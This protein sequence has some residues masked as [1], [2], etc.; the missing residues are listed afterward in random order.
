MKRDAK[1]D[2]LAFGKAD[3]EIRHEKHENTP[4]RRVERDRLP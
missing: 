2:F 3:S 4:E 1:P